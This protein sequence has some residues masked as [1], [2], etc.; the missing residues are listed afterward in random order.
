[1]RKEKGDKA[2]RKAVLDLPDYAPPAGLWEDIASDL[3]AV[4]AVKKKTGFGWIKYAAV[5][6][7]VLTSGILWYNLIYA[8]SGIS[9]DEELSDFDSKIEMVQVVDSGFELFLEEECTGYREVCEMPEFKTLITQ[10][11]EVEAEVTNIANMI[12]TTGFD[13]FLY[14]AKTKADQETVRI[15]KELVKLLRG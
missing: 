7:L 3:E 5:F 2:L 8:S 10:L 11:T 15:K 12:E 9:F 13:E 14:K 1:M 6:A 4:V